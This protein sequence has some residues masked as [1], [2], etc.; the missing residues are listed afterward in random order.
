MN[1]RWGLVYINLWR[2]MP[3]YYMLMWSRFAEKANQDLD[4]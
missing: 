1:Y 4:V 2:I 3:T